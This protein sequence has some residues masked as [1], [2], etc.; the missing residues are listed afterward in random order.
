MP[1]FSQERFHVLVQNLIVYN[2]QF[3]IFID[4]NYAVISKKKISVSPLHR[5][6]QSCNNFMEGD[7]LK[8]L[9]RTEN[10]KQIFPYF[11]P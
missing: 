8:E 6:L 10:L 7:F 11:H 9:H 5:S 4:S 2:L 3:H 1:R